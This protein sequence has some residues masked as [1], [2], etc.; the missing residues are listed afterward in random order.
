MRVFQDGFDISAPANWSSERLT[1][2][3]LPTGRH[4]Q[5][6][7]WDQIASGMG[8]VYQLPAQERPLRLTELRTI[9]HW[10]GFGRHLRSVPGVA[11]VNSWGGYEKQYHVLFDPPCWPNTT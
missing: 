11:E 3:E 6:R 2:A 10:P 9:Q 4:A 5:A 7:S 1:V 8:E